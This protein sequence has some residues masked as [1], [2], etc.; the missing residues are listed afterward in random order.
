MTI[1]PE[2]RELSPEA[3]LRSFIKKYDPKEQKLFRSVRAAVRQRF[4]TVNEL[5]YD[6]PNSVVISYS[7]T[8]RGI[9]AIVA[10][11][12]RPDGVFLPPNPLLT[13]EGNK[14]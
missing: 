3:E 9:E 1:K 12:A 2:N 14:R 11:A 13:Q 7:P 10:I 5:V 8:N 4:P 6:Y